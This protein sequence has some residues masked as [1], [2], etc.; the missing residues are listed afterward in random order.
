MP[1]YDS[2]SRPINYLRISITDRCNLRCVYCMPEEGVPD[3]LRHDEIL[4]YEEIARVVEAAAGLG[5]SKVRITGG[6]PLVRLGLVDLVEMIAA[7]PG[8]DDISMTTN[9]ILL[10]QH[11]Y[12]LRDAGLHRVNVSLDTLD[13]GKF[14][15]I[16]RR[17]ELRS[18]LDGISVAEKAGLLPIKINVVVMRGLNEDEVTRFARLTLE[19]EWHVRFIELMPVGRMANMAGIGHVPIAEVRAKIESSL[20]ILQPAE[21]GRG[22]GPAR[23][24]RL[25]GG[26]G[27]IGFIAAVSEHFCFHC[28]RLRLTADG[29]LRPCLLSD[30]EVNV[31]QALR[32]RAEIS[33]V[34]ALL[35]QAVGA[36]PAGH[37][38]AEGQTAV[39]RQMSQIGG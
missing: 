4:S 18:V 5:I 15:E 6:E 3:K 27:T 8:I 33:V 14:R 7:V 23:Y 38:L 34:Q 24:C 25:P 19:K 29:R 12:A 10:A 21:T 1:C 13:E 35:C 31:R 32:A 17:G 30:N 28:N 22:N 26:V 2:L 9:G 36:K 20:G 11:A 39:S 37:H 16:T